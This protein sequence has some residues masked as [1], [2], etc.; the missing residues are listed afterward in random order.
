MYVHVHI[1]FFVIMHYA[2]KIHI[3]PALSLLSVTPAGKKR[4]A[5]GRYSDGYWLQSSEFE[6][7]DKEPDLRRDPVEKDTHPDFDPGRSLREH[8]AAPIFN[9][10]IF[11]NNR[12]F[13]TCLNFS[14]L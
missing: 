7:E 5:A 8:I 13:N 6:G 1:Y 3:T 10:H 14:I 4:G 2:M 9:K 12:H 11:I